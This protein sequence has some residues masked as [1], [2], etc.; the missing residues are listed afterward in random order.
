MIKFILKKVNDVRWKKEFKNVNGLNALR[1]EAVSSY[2]LLD[3]RLFVGKI[4]KLWY[5]QKIT[6]A[7]L[8]LLW[9][10]MAYQVKLKHT[11]PGW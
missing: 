6:K 10:C 1:D 3:L 4:N 8:I 5:Y 11:I 2:V 9:I 7:S